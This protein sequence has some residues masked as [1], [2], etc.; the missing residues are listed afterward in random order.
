MRW[1]KTGILLFLLNIS[2]TV[3]AQGGAGTTGGGAGTTGGG[4]GVGFPNPLK[5]GNFGC[6]ADKIIGG[7]YRIAVPIVAIMVLVGG[8]QILTAGGDPEKFKK[9]KQTIFYAV[10]GLVAI[11][12]AG[13]VVGIIQSAFGG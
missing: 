9:G 2:G 12:L 13:G 7:L 11:I 8:F 10:I 5:C 6:V 1:L 4:S 3:F